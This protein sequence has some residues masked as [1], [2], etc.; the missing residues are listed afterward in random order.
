MSRANA[1]NAANVYILP[2]ERTGARTAAICPFWI[3]EIIPKLNII[4][5]FMW[6][7]LSPPFFP[8]NY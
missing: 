4:I 7:I 8:H 5:N 2:L 1:R 3:P 6:L